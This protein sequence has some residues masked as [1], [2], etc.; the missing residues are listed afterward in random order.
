MANVYL[1]LEAKAARKRGSWPKSK[2]WEDKPKRSR[3]IIPQGMPMNLSELRDL[4]GL[5][6]KLTDNLKTLLHSFEE[7][8]PT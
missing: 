8:P 3:K 6:V 4:H 1:R 5:I 7:P 2:D